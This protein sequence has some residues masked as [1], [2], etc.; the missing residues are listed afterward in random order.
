MRFYSG[1]S[2]DMDM[3]RYVERVRAVIRRANRPVWF[4]TGLVGC[5]CWVP[6]SHLRRDS[7]PMH[8]GLGGPGVT[9]RHVHARSSPVPVQSSPFN[10]QRY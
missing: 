2:M 1:L 9:Q 3:D 7:T 10:P 5:C 4:G 6:T 8:G